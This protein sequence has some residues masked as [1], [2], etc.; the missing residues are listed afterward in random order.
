M[1]KLTGQKFQNRVN[2]L[3]KTD[4]EAKL[5]LVLI[6]GKYTSGILMV[7]IAINKVKIKTRKTQQF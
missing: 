3:E 4:W 1:R 2:Q 5:F 6:F 7:M